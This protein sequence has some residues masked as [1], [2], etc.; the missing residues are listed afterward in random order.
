M[1]YRHEIKHEITYSDM[2]SIKSRLDAVAKLDPHAKD[3]K[4][5]IRSLYFDSPRDKALKENMSGVSRREKYRIRFYNG[6]LDEIHLERKTKI[7][8]LGYKDQCPITKTECEMLLQGDYSWMLESGRD[9]IVDLYIKMIFDCL[10]PKAIVEYTRMPYI[11]DAGNVR[12]TFDYDIR[13]T[14]NAEDFLD[15]GCPSLT[16]TGSP[17]IM[18]V[19]WDN[20]LPGIISDCVQTNRARAEAFS[21]YSAS[22]M[23]D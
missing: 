18:E 4:Y 11:Y 14:T 19:K 6:N 1:Q 12:V 5:I 20:F 21:K 8:G 17:I 3:G 2:L 15:P 7:S 23:Y 9:L 16:V 22:R 10:R 13:T